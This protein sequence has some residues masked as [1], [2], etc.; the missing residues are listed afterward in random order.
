MFEPGHK[1]SL[2]H[3]KKLLTTGSVR[4]KSMASFLKTKKLLPANIKCIGNPGN[5]A[6]LTEVIL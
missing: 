4:I 1:V 6:F 2:L 5:G 3:S